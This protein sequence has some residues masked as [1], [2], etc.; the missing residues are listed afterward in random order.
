MK[1][2]SAYNYSVEKFL[3]NKQRYQP[4][5]LP[6]NFSDEE[7]VRDWSLAARDIVYLEK[8]KGFCRKNN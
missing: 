3:T 6:E 5:S 2:N 1:Q 4:I 7:M 8:Y